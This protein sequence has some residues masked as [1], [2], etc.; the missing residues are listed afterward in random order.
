MGVARLGAGAG[1]AEAVQATAYVA[2][3]CRAEESRQSAPRLVD[4]FAELFAPAPADARPAPAALRGLLAA[5]RDEVVARTAGIDRALRDAL[6]SGPAPVVLNLGAG[7]CT[8]P[9][10][11]DLSGCRL[12]VECDAA[13]VVAR[14]DRLL[15]TH[16]PSCPVVRVAADLRDGRQL[17]RL[18][19]GVERGDPFVVVTEGLLVYLSPTEVGALAR[20]LAAAPGPAWWLADVV[21]PESARA[22]AVVAGR[23]GAGVTLHGLES[24]APFEAAGWAVADYRI[25]PV[26]RRAPGTFSGAAP[27]GAFSRAAPGGAFSSA[28]RGGA[29]AGAARDGPPAA[30]ISRRV[31]D[32][33]VTLCRP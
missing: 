1:V 2:A 30:A 14:K 6:A 29:F 16:R 31:V 15:A 23:A 10:R 32:G 25:L 19:A 21:S 11:L 12:V 7:F 9:Y 24:L 33:V 18:L 20:G 5:G 22:M 13:P 27:G 28:G 8:R 26:T 3:A 4:P 17:A